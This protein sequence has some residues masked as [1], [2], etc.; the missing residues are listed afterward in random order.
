LDGIEL[1]MDRRCWTGQVINLI[2]F[3]KERVRYIVPQQF[4]VTVLEK[5]HDVLPPSREEII[6]AQ[7]FMTSTQ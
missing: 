4:K 6:D 7:D 3:D 2:D 1:V 5:M